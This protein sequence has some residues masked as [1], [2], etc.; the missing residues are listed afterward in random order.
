[1][2]TTYTKMYG[3][4][5]IK[6]WKDLLDCL[7]RSTHRCE[8]CHS[9]VAQNVFLSGNNRRAKKIRQWP[10]NKTL[11][12]AVFPGTQTAIRVMHSALMY[13]MYNELIVLL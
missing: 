13:S 11:K 12:M 7:S 9:N 4:Q 8:N 5:N 1:M 6:I 3:Q 10:V 2:K